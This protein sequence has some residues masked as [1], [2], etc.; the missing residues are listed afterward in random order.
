MTSSVFE[1][2]IH[3]DTTVLIQNERCLSKLTHERLL[4]DPSGAGM[5]VGV[6]CGR[7]GGARHTDGSFSTSSP[8]S[9]PIT[10]NRLPGSATS[11]LLPRPTGSGA[12]L[13]QLP[14][15]GS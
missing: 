5:W 4:Y 1:D 13:A 10:I 12:R 3:F 2:V 11:A 15:A 7:G 6:G 8:V 14:V 9:P